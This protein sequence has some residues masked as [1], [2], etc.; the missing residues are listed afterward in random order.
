LNESRSVSKFDNTP[1]LVLGHRHSGKRTFIDSLY[2]LSRTEMPKKAVVE[3]ARLRD[4]NLTSV[5]DYAYLNVV[6]LRDPDNR[7]HAKL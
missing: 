7:T 6:N 3:S 5:I 4:K 2:D 1:V